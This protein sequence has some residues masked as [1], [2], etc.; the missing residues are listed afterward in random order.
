MLPHPGPLLLS[1]FSSWVIHLLETRGS[2]HFPDIRPR[3]LLAR[4]CRIVA[5][6]VVHWHR[7]SGGV[8]FKMN[9]LPD[10]RYAIPWD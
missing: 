5:L 3:M 4:P 8:G 2:Q 7:R 10:V 6:R 9:E 1:I